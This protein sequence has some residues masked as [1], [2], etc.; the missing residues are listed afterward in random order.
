MGRPTSSMCG[1]VQHKTEHPRRASPDPQGGTPSD[2]RSRILGVAGRGHSAPETEKK[3]LLLWPQ[4]PQRQK[5]PHPEASRVRLRR[6]E[7]PSPS[8]PKA[9][10]R[11][12]AASAAQGGVSNPARQRR[13]GVCPT[14]AQGGVPYYLNRDWGTTLSSPST[15]DRYLAMARISAGVYCLAMPAM[16][17]LERPTTLLP[18]TV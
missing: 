9:P 14:W 7:M 16:M 13:R 4:D 3:T 5:C 17:P 10:E 15:V 6:P 18:S 2:R 8:K 1:S 11:G 12:E